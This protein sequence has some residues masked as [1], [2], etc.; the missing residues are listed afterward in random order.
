MIS[1]F[2]YGDSIM[3]EE[4]A[5]IC[6]YLIISAWLLNLVFSIINNAIGIYRN[7]KRIIIGIVK[8]RRDKVYRINTITEVEGKNTKTLTLEI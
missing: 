2:I 6:I 8:F 4:N 1:G 5:D 3:S 7:I